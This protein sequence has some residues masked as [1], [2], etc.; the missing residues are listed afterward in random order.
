MA[1]Q[2]DKL[3]SK[4]GTQNQLGGVA[5]EIHRIKVLSLHLQVSV[6]SAV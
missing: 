4:N 5:A 2:S 1:E 3:Y 6:L